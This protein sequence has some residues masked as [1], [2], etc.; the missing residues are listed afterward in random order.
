MVRSR[1][2][3]L[4]EAWR[5]WALA[6][7][8]SEEGWQ[9]D[10]PK[11]A[12][13]IEEAARTMFQGTIDP[14]S[15]S[16]LAECWAASEEGEE[17]LEYARNRIDDCWRVVEKLAGSELPACRWQIYE[18]AACG[19]PKAEVLLRNG[20]QDSDPY[21]RR[22]AILAL[23]RLRPHDARALAESL[24]I[25]PDPYIRQAAIEMVLVANDEAFKAHAL[26]VL[27]EDVA[28]NVRSAARRHMSSSS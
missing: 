24:M 26:R 6:A 9:S 5:A 25:D 15:L 10:F 17:L 14:L 12:T 16:L 13:L 21:A 11:W 8:R 1:F 27:A 18:A 3:E 2:Q 28:E 22:R 7:D 19:G 20:L 4:V 23:A